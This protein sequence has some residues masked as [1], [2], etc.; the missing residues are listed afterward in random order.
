MSGGIEQALEGHLLAATSAMEQQLDAEI[1]RL[2]KMDEDDM[3][4]S[5]HT[6]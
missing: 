3:E 5:N 6:W 2:D 1:E 4:V